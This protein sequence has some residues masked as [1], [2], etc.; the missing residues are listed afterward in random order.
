[1]FISLQKIGSHEHLYLVENTR[2]GGRHVQHAIKALARRDEIE[3][4]DTL[5][6]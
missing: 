4:S 5:D 2:E 3:N 1:M 6:G